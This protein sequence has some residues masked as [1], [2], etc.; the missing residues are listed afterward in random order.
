MLFQPGFFTA[1]AQR[2]Q[3]SFIEFERH[4]IKDQALKIATEAHGKNSKYSVLFRVLPW[5]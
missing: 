3:S 2:T 1:K 5:P 4:L